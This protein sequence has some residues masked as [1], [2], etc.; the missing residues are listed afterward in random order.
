MNHTQALTALILSFAFVS[1]ARTVDQLVPQNAT[2]DQVSYDG[3]R[4]VRLIAA[5]TAEKGASYAV[6]RNARFQNGSIEVALAGAGAEGYPANLEITP[7]LGGSEKAAAGQKIYFDRAHG[8]LPWPPQ[9][10]EIG[11]RLGYELLPGNAPIT[12]AA[13]SGSR[14]AYLR[15]PNKTFEPAEKQAL[16]AHVKGGGISAGCS[17]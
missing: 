5:P 15:A 10:E 13:L 7:K 6:V 2:L 3:R 12:S 1:Q 11:K 14:L 9:M 8:E 17:R 16:I 4:T